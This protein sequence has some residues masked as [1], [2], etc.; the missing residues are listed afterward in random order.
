MSL[1]SSAAQAEP[2]KQIKQ[3]ARAAQA[4]PTEQIAQVTQAAQA[5]PDPQAAP[6]D[7]WETVNRV[8]FPVK[9]QDLTMPLYVVEWTRPHPQA[10]SD[11]AFANLARIDVKAMGPSELRQLID[12]SITRRPNTPEQE[13]LSIGSRSRLTVAA[14]KHVSL[15]TFF[16]AFPGSYWQRWTTVRTVR[17]SAELSGEGTVILMKSNA[18]G[19]ASPVATIE[20]REKTASSHSVDL[21]LNGM[22]DGGYLWAELRSDGDSPFT[23]QDAQWAVPARDRVMPD[24]SKLSIAITTFNRAPY[25][26][27]Q[28]KAIAGEPALRERLDTVYCIDQGTDLVRD[29][30]GF[31]DTAA[32][33]GN[34]LTYLR[35]G[36][37]GGSGGFTR[38]MVETLKAGDSAYALMLDDDAISEPESIVRAVNFADYAKR[39]TIVG[40]GMF[41]IDNRTVLRTLGEHWDAHT[42]MHGP[43][44][45][46]PYDHDFAQQPLAESP[47]WHQR[48]ET[49][50]NAWW[51]CLIPTRVIRDIGL[52][53]PVFIKHDDVEFGLRARSAGYRT[54]S[55]PGV[56][57]WHQAWHDKDPM[58]TWE[59]YFVLRNFWIQA[60]RRF[61][62]PNP[63][64]L[65]EMVAGDVNAGCKLTYSAMQLRNMAMRDLLEGPQA[66]AQ[67]M[68]GLIDR[69]RKA[70]EGFEDSTVIRDL[71]S[72]PEPERLYVNEMGAM[73]GRQIKGML[74]RMLLSNLFTGR[75]GR[76]SRRPQIMVPYKDVQ[77]TTFDHIDSALATT[78]DGNAVEWL[79]R[80]N[81]LYRRM[82]RANM[83]LYI[84]LLRNWDK[85]AKAYRSPEFTSVATWER[86][87]KA[88]NGE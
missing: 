51:M 27:N 35:Q 5:A 9:D 28:L 24:G 86:I 21:A 83:R 50:Y 20:H 4:A 58:R 2:T 69:V 30:P 74:L 7:A 14:H 85:Y 40:G 26:H 78:P 82:F 80:D 65:K 34:Q 45:G 1:M 11:N 46:R 32:D 49:D 41:H 68:P 17:F 6:A 43:L 13:L 31:A 44:I 57:V 71:E 25:C 47:E 81:R 77:W 15:C 19:L 39:P 33:L 79:R 63:S 16:N 62:K 38:G 8:V 42:N 54:V 84:K 59:C 10:A 48:I 64:F 3:T 87:F 72:I 56:A 23:M 22:L 75:N 67:G 12:S 70:R 73:S 36:N 55:L 88:A 29:Q 60:L 53:M 76:S 37:L 66:V 18:R 61:D 52:P